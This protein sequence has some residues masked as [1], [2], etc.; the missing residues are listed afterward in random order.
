MQS[1]REGSRTLP[2]DLVLLLVQNVEAA[3]RHGYKPLPEPTLLSLFKPSD[4]SNFWPV[5]KNLPR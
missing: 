4:T 2:G 3:F 5:L 1:L